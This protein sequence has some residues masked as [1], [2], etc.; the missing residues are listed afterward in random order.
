MFSFKPLTDKKKTDK[1]ETSVTEYNKKIVKFF[2]CKYVSNE[3]F[4]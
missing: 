2:N 1:T 4:I 3:L